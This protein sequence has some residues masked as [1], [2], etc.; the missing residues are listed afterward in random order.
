MMLSRR[1]LSSSAAASSFRGPA[2][3]LVQFGEPTVA[4]KMEEE[5]YSA[6]QLSADEVLV[7]VLAAPV[8]PADWNTVEGK[9]GSLPSLPGYVG[10]EGAAEV[11]AV[12]SAVSQ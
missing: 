8:N 6:S 5:S 4:L 9:Y 3:K 11:Q 10:L 7:R 12:G 2:A 1:L